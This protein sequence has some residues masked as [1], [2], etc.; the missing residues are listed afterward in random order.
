MERYEKH[1][2]WGGRGE[3]RESHTPFRGRRGRRKNK[4]IKMIQLRASNTKRPSFGRLIA[5]GA[6]NAIRKKGMGETTAAHGLIERKETPRN[7]KGGCRTNRGSKG[8]T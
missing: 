1:G 7:M 2:A 6:L 4:F 5:K 3:K 8:T